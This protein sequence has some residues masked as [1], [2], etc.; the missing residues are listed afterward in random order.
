MSRFGIVAFV[1]R[2]EEMANLRLLN[3]F[4]LG[5]FPE[6]RSPS[7]TCL[8]RLIL[9]FYLQTIDDCID[10]ES[11]TVCAFNPAGSLLAAGCT[12][13]R[14]AIYNTLTRGRMRL[15]WGH[16]SQVE[17]I[18]WSGG[19]NGGRWLLSVGADAVV[20]V[21]DVERGERVATVLLENPALCAHFN[22]RQ[23]RELLISQGR[24]W[25]LL[26]TLTQPSPETGL[27]RVESRE[28]VS[29]EAIVEMPPSKTAPLMATY[30]RTGDRLI[31]ASTTGI[32]IV[33]RYSLKVIG[34]VKQSQGVVQELKVSADNRHL[35]VNAKDRVLRVYALSLPD[36]QLVHK[37][38]DLVDRIQWT[39][40]DISAD[41]EYVV[42]GRQSDHNLHVWDRASGVL[43][44]ILEGT[45]EP[46][47]S[48]SWHPV[49]PVIASVSPYGLIYL[50]TKPNE[51]EWSA[52][53][54]G[55]KTLESN[56]TYQERED[57]FDLVPDEELAKRKQ[58]LE[59]QPVDCWSNADPIEYIEE[60]AIRGKEVPSQ[61][62]TM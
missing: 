2:N 48:V 62:A 53:A 18:N 7:P 15:F 35:L 41:S 34:S 9:Y 38:A 44:K 19:D 56:I 16:I 49:R 31:I 54:P 10:G 17:C 22:P 28:L 60:L 4:D 50:W 39:C 43:L 1:S 47:T 20:L 33:D 6:V 26:V 21:W 30:D 46:A 27:S 55:F 24:S 14:L 36:I 52:F 12:D 25:P 61:H 29:D 5:S 8:S 3:P 57:E 32:S 13:G 23:P 37:F 40:C 58:I 11:F 59:D 45:A 42:A 51:D